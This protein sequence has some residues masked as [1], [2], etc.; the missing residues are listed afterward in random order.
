MDSERKRLKFEI[1]L[2]RY[3]TN[4]HRVLLTNLMFAAP[5]AVFFAAVYF[6]NTALFHGAVSVPVMLLV[7]I[8]LFPFYAGV[9]LVCRNIARGDGDQPVVKSFWKAVKDNF[10]PFLLHGVLIYVAT[11][12]SFLSISLYISLL[13]S[14]WFFYVLLFFS[15]SLPQYLLLILFWLPMM[16]IQ[17]KAFSKG[18]TPYLR[19][20]RWFCVLIGMIPALVLSAILGLNSALGSALGTMFLSFGNAFMFGGLLATLPDQESFDRFQ[21]KISK[22]KS[23]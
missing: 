20:A 16:I 13:P 18:F 10:L 6:L 14:G 4:F 3:F 17:F 21:E 5:S 8:P 12:L 22:S 7:I 15:F 2:E 9:V 19:K 11:M 23:V 1:L